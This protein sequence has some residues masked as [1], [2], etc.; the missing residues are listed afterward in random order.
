MGS[1]IPFCIGVSWLNLAYSRLFM[2][3]WVGLVW[4]GLS[5]GDI[6]ADLPNSQQL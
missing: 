2:L 4:C 5:F 3:E 6:A 1:C